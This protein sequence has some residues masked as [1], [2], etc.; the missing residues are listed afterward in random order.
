MTRYIEPEQKPLNLIEY[1]A[2]TQLN[3][4]NNRNFLRIKRWAQ[5]RNW[6]HLRFSFGHCLLLVAA[7][8]LVS[9][10]LSDTLH[11]QE[12]ARPMPGQEPS[13]ELRTAIMEFHSLLDQKQAAGADVSQA[14]QLNMASREAHRAGDAAGALRLLEEAIQALKTGT[15]KAKALVFA[16]IS[17]KYQNSPFAIH[18]PFSID[19]TTQ[20]SNAYITACIKDMGAR[21]IRIIAP[22]LYVLSDQINDLVTNNVL[23]YVDVGAENDQELKNLVAAFKN[24][25][26]YWRVI[27]EPD[28]PYGFADRPLDYLA[29]LKRVYATIK[30][31]SPGALV[32][33]GGLANGRDVDERSQGPTFLKTLLDNGGGDYFDIFAF[34]FQ[35]SAHDYEKLTQTVTVYRNLL[36]RYGYHKPIWITEF[37]TYDGQPVPQMGGPMEPVYQSEIQQASAMVKMYVYGLSLGIEKM[38]W[39][40]MVERHRF[41]GV[42]NSYFDNVGFIHNPCNDGNDETACTGKNYRKLAYHAYKFMAE[43]LEGSDWKSIRTIS[44]TNGLFVYRFNKA[45]T[46]KPVWV[47]WSDSLEN[48]T[49]ALDVEG[50]GNVSVKT[51]VP[52]GET[53]LDVSDYTTA[54]TR[55][56]K[57]VQGTSLL[58]NLTEVPVYVMAP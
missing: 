26:Q 52:N 23:M 20:F 13:P 35:G 43:T 33:I 49:F 8:C 29:I 21:C 25:I 44:N 37:G 45:D 24:T 47:A 6:T 40:L 11:S 17:L 38:F 2:D 9:I 27:N 50:A 7:V 36:E 14:V 55:V 34:H 15:S 5:R 46:G 30:A 58:L 42:R 39:S 28:A 54:F 32:S 3:R 48:R 51:S 12:I 1:K 4:R 10:T 22:E 16:P 57:A 19:K 31:E 41:G 56:D 18:A 53:G